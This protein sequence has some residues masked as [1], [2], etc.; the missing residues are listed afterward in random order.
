MSTE[1]LYPI[2]C[3]SLM[4]KEYRMKSGGGADFVGYHCQDCGRRVSV[5]MQKKEAGESGRTPDGAASMK[6]E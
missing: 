2:C 6:G 4:A 3:D 5:P 1:S